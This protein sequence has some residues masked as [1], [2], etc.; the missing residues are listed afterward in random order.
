MS[1][2]ECVSFPGSEKHMASTVNKK[3][4]NSVT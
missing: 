4:M 1:H 3:N 2:E